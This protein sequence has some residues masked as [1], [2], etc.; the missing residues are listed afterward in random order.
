MDQHHS[1][2]LEKTVLQADASAASPASIMTEISAY[3]TFTRE[4]YSTNLVL[5]IVVNTQ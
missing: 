3:I 4:N 5:F 2:R 1:R